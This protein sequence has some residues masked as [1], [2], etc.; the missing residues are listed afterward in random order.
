MGFVKD[1]RYLPET[2][3]PPYRLAHANITWRQLEPEKGIYAFDELEKQYHFDEWN[4]RG[5]KFI[6]RLVL[7]YPRDTPHMDIPDWVYDETD[8]RGTIYDTKWGMG[9]SPDYFNQTL[10]R[11]HEKLIEQ[12]AARYNDD[13]RIAFVQ[14]GSLGHW[15]EWHTMNDEFTTIPFPQI[16]VADQYVQPYIKYF[17]NKHLMMR[18]PYPLAEQNKMGLFNDAFGNKEA[19]V[20]EFN[21]WVDHG[22]TFWLTDEPMPSMPNYWMEAPSGGEFSSKDSEE[23]YFEN[24]QIEETLSQIKLTHPSWIGPYIIQDFPTNGEISR[25]VDRF[26]KTIGYRFSILS[27]KHDKQVDPGDKLNIDMKWHNAG[28]APFYYNWPLELALADADGNIAVKQITPE[29]IKTWLPGNQITQQSLSI[30]KDLADGIYTLCVAILDPDSGQPGL[31]LAMG[32]K[33]SDG[34]YHLGTVKVGSG[35]HKQ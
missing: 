5:V 13:P 6:I 26:M 23:Y 17:T 31:L 35:D 3:N 33:R 2:E 32:D 34:R 27:E 24:D 16:A 25:N 29:D 4:S 11:M 21:D 22:Y 7:D 12:L 19:T 15:G 30:P 20:D 28:V 10:I 18:R 9:F 14:M 1:A 8:Q